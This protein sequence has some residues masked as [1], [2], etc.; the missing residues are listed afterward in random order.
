MKKLGYKIYSD[1]TSPNRKCYGK[2]WRKSSLLRN[3]LKVEFKT[4]TLKTDVFKIGNLIFG[5][6]ISKCELLFLGQANSSF[7]LSRILIL[8]FPINRTFL[9][10]SPSLS[11][12]PHPIE[13]PFQHNPYHVLHR[14]SYF[15]LPHLTTYHHKYCIYQ[16]MCQSKPIRF[17]IKL[18]T[19]H[20][21][22]WA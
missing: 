14:F 12:L 19:D 11:F 4:W 18:Y 15:V 9:L 6:L 10:P 21:T 20:N 3:L 13:I 7:D 17:N 16:R 22:L 5:K 8:Q 2:Y 1:I